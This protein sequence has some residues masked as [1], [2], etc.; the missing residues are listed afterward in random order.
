MKWLN[1][2]TEGRHLLEMATIAKIEEIRRESRRAFKEH[3][4]ADEI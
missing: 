2:T 4:E 3:I 1:S